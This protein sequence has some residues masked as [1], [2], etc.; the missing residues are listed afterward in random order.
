MYCR[1]TSTEDEHFRDFP[2]EPNSTSEDI[3]T[4]RFIAKS[5]GR[6]RA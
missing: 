2:V 1:D 3:A 4:H 5:G 6:G